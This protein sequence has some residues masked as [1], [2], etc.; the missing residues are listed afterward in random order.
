MIRTRH[1]INAVATVT[2]FITVLY[3]IFIYANLH[4]Q[5]QVILSL[6]TNCRAYEIQFPDSRRK[7]SDRK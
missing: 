4:S 1:K 5:T 6:Y 3:R 7:I 2:F